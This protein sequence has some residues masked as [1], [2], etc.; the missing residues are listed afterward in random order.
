MIAITRKVS[1]QDNMALSLIRGSETSELGAGTGL[2]ASRRTAPHRRNGKA[3][4]VPV[5]QSAGPHVF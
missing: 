5:Q 3:I 2:N 1:A 4:S